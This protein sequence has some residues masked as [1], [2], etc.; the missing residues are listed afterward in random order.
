[1]V[2]AEELLHFFALA[3]RRGEIIE[4]LSGGQR[5]RLL[6]ARALINEPRLLILDEPTIG[7]DPQARHLMWERVEILKEQGN[8]N[9]LTSH[10]LEQYSVA[11]IT[12]AGETLKKDIASTVNQV[13]PKVDKDIEA[14][15]EDF[16]RL[17]NKGGA[18]WRE[19]SNEAEYIGKLSLD[20][21]GAF[22]LH[23]V[24]GLSEW[25]KNLSDKLDSSLSYRTG[26][27]THGGEFTCVGC[28]AEIH[29]KKP[30]RLPPCPKCA[31]AE[32][33]RS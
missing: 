26:E 11:T 19:I 25:T 5:R 13:R 9:L 7:L 24:R 17:Y 10:Y 29:L 8:I 12:R 21:G 18:L 15:R 28:G 3:N 33:C 22:F 4:H 27:I 32:F 20:K 30:G 31:K 16:N 1:M 2:R 6:L 14:A 23:L